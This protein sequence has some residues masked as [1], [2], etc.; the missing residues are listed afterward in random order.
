MAKSDLPSMYATPLVYEAFFN[1]GLA[2]LPFY[3]AWARDAAGPVLEL[4]CGTGR[5]LW[6]LR[7]TGLPVE[8]LD[9]SPEM[10]EACRAEGKRQSLEAALHQGD[11][12]SFDLGK[13]FAGIALPFNGLQHLHSAE[14]LDAFF[15]RLRAHLLPGGAFALDVHLPQPALL[16]RDPQERYG[17]DEGPVAPNGERVIAEQSAYDVVTQVQSQTWTLASADGSTREIRLGLRQFFPQELQRLLQ[18]QGFELQ[19]VWGGFDVR[20]LGAQAFKQVVRAR[21]R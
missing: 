6:A 14:D 5:L 13:R 2:D 9:A 12:R 19:S 15:E 16:A 4:G 7:K 21:L 20:P 11:W 10:L 8:G 17:V 1:P 18:A 3:T